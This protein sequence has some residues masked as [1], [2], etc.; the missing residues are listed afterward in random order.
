MK[1]T[2]IL[3]ALFL[4]S[5]CRNNM[6]HP[7]KKTNYYFIS[8]NQNRNKVDTFPLTNLTSKDSLYDLIAKHPFWYKKQSHLI[9]MYSNDRRSPLDGG[10]LVYILDSIGVVYGRST[11]WPGFSFLTSDN[12]SINDLLSFSLAK[13]IS[14][15]SLRCYHC[16]DRFTHLPEKIVFKME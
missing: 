13:I 10:S 1:S 14:E 11:T 2:L 16:D 15:S 7:V 6:H 8:Y 9:Q 3:L 5:N 12:D 4:F